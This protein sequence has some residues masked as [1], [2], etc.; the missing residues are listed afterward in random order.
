[1][2][3]WPRLWGS[4]LQ[5]TFHMLL[6]RAAAEL[7]ARHGVEPHFGAGLPLGGCHKSGRQLCRVHLRGCFLRSHGLQYATLDIFNR[8]I[9]VMTKISDT[10]PSA[11][12]RPCMCVR[13]NEPA[14][15]GRC[16]LPSR[17]CQQLR[18][19]VLWHLYPA[20]CLI[21]IHAMH[22]DALRASYILQ[23]GM[24]ACTALACPARLLINSCSSHK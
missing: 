10:I 22:D 23:N 11:H 7:D 20:G 12:V 5:P 6:P 13:G 15:S 2:W 14:F 1:M 24:H 4:T 8:M 21:I 9:T 3:R 17:V 16:R 18:A 19:A